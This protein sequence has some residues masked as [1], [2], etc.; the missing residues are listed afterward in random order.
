M[1]QD[2][3]SET[4]EEIEVD[5]KN[6]AVE[7]PAAQCSMFNLWRRFMDFSLHQFFRDITVVGKHNVPK[8][9]PVIF[10]GNHSNQFVDGAILFFTSPR[11]A[12]FMVAAKSMRR[13]CLKSMFG[14]AKSIP[15]ERAADLA[16]KGTGQITFDDVTTVIGHNTNF[17]KEFAKGD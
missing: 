3:T 17:T 13:P 7:V 10:C 14:W 15:V 12:R 2:D 8:K 16:K 1:V 4:E 9:G 5:D 6:V 11:D